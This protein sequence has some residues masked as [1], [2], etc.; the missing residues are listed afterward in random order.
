[1][2]QLHN[3]PEGIG[4]RSG[5][6]DGLCVVGHNYKAFVRHR[7]AGACFFFRVDKI[8]FITMISAIFKMENIL[9]CS[10]ED[11]RLTYNL[12]RNYD[13]L[14][15]PQLEFYL[16]NTAPLTFMLRQVYIKHGEHLPSLF[17]K[18]MIVKLV[19]GKWPLGDCIDC[20]KHTFV[21]QKKDRS[22]FSMLLT[23]FTWMCSLPKKEQ[24]IELDN[25]KTYYIK[26]VGELV[27]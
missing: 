6:H 13:E 4:P 27:T 8:E 3:A 21:F 12:K 1:M 16:V 17:E 23:G 24:Q 26:V 7:L 25:S 10:S 5:A 19:S 9:F 18:D 22:K 20:G 15:N 14:L 11:N 2:P